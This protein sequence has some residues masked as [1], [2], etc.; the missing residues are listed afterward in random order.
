MTTAAYAWPS[1]FSVIAQENI[2]EHILRA[3]A[4][5]CRRLHRGN[6]RELGGYSCAHLHGPR[7]GGLKLDKNR[8]EQAV[9]KEAQI[10]TDGSNLKAFV[11][12]TDEE[13]LIARDT[14]RCIAGEPHPS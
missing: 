2:L 11:I 7:M 6:R 10:S 1:R 5:R 3:W 9:G 13:L 8:N 4:G 14:V 12:P